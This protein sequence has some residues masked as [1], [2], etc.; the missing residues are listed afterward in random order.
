MSILG[1]TES[2]NLTFTKLDRLES[3]NGDLATLLDSNVKS[4]L[5]YN[6]GLKSLEKSLVNEFVFA[7]LTK[8]FYQSLESI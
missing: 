1:L 8:F 6:S 2:N 7:K 5:I 4:L 3:E